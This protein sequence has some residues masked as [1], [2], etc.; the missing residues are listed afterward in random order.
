MALFVIGFV[1]SYGFRIAMAG[2]AE[3]AKQ[4]NKSELMPLIQL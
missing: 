4:F 3:I 1:N 2:S